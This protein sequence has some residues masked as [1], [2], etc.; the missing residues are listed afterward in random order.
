MDKTLWQLMNEKGTVSIA[1]NL[2]KKPQAIS[3]WKRR[4][5]IPSTYIKSL[6]KTLNVKTDFILEHI[7]TDEILLKDKNA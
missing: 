2:N 4:K 6:A 3:N 1:K 5:M 7:S